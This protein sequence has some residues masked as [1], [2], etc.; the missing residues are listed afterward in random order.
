MLGALGPDP[1]CFQKDVKRIKAAGPAARRRSSRTLKSGWNR[2]I[3]Y[4]EQLSRQTIFRSNLMRDR[5][6]PQGE[7]LKLAILP[8]FACD[9]AGT[10]SPAGW[11]DSGTIVAGAG[12]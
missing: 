7:M 6:D 8:T 12:R 1:A 11:Q 10:P 4:R 9:A 3:V 5:N 2:T